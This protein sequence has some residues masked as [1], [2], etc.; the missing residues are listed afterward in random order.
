M[1]HSIRLERGSAGTLDLRLS[2]R[3]LPDPGDPGSGA[4]RRLP[5][6]GARLRNRRLLRLCPGAS[7]LE[8][9]GAAGADRADG[10]ALG[11]AAAPSHRG[12]R[13]RRAGGALVSAISSRADGGGTAS[14]A[15]LLGLADGAVSLPAPSELHHRQF[16]GAGDDTAP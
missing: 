11:A 12:N 6:P 1:A 8:S 16:G 5:P 15:D 2:C 13:D 14:V 4:G 9:G 10:L 7:A 3:G